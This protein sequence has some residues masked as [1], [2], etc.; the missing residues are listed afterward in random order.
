MAGN[1]HRQL[2]TDCIIQNVSAAFSELT[3]GA[4]RLMYI[5]QEAAALI[6]QAQFRKWERMNARLERKEMRPVL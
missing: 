1:N 3:D 6:Q 4:R 2:E 5:R